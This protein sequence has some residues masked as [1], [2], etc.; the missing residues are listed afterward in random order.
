MHESNRRL[1]S[2]RSFSHIP[3][4]IDAED[5]NNASSI[6][7][8]NVPDQNNI[9]KLARMIEKTRNI[10]L[11][12][13]NK[14]ITGNTSLV[15]QQHQHLEQILYPMQHQ[16]ESWAQKQSKKVLKKSQPKPIENNPPP[17]P[18]ENDPHIFDLL[19]KD[20]SS[21]IHYGKSD[22]TITSATVEKLIEKITREMGTYYAY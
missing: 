9:N 12:F 18:I 10:S 21:F 14:T 20:A 15:N 19:A 6:V 17:L 13:P 1:Q 11:L 7:V 5:N 16:Y 22:A 4:A 8:V 3:A 2:S